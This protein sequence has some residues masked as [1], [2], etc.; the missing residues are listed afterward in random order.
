MGSIIDRI[1]RIVLGVSKENIN[2]MQKQLLDISVRVKDV[3]DR[4]YDIAARTKDSQDR[5]YDTMGR[6][7]EYGERLLDTAI[8]TRDTQDRIYDVLWQQKTSSYQRQMLFWQIYKLPEESLG[9]AKNRFFRALPKAGGIARKNQLLLLKLLRKVHKACVEN[10]LSYWMDFGTLLG[11]VRHAGFI[12]WDDDIDLGM[13]R[14]EAGKLFEV[15]KKDPDIMVRNIFINGRENGVH[16]VYQVLWK[17]DKIELYS[18]SIDV[19]L[20]DYCLAEPCQENWDFWLKNKKLLVEDSRQYPEFRGFS[21]LTSSE[22]TQATLKNIFSK[23]YEAVDSVF[24]FK[25]VVTDNIAFGFDNLDYPNPDIHMFKK[26]M[27][28]PLKN[29]VFEGEEFFVPNNYMD[30][31]NPIYEDIYSLP[32]DMLSHVHVKIDKEV[33]EVIEALYKWHIKDIELNEPAMRKN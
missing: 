13:M 1:R 32:S 8:R 33:E 22:K 18:S 7:A 4:I 14:D 21:E 24:K 31:L 12:P 15:L 2:D 17:H 27:I 28:F 16:H 29:L 20:Y 5:I 30:F 10:N 11:A 9:E 19:F 25:E 23:R 6:Q 3:Q 26:N